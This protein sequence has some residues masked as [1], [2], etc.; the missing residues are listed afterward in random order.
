MRVPAGHIR[1]GAGRCIWAR[2]SRSEEGTCIH[3][4]KSYQHTVLNGVEDIGP[5]WHRHGERQQGG[6]SRDASSRA[7]RQVCLHERQDMPH[8]GCS[9]ATS[10][11][12]IP[13]V[14]HYTGLTGQD[15]S[16]ATG[17]R[18]CYGAAGRV[19]D[20]WRHCWSSC[21]IA[22]CAPALYQRPPMLCDTTPA[23]PATNSS[24]SPSLSSTPAYTS[25]PSGS[26][27]LRPVGPRIPLH[28]LAHLA[29]P[30]LPKAL[31]GT[32]LSAK[33]P[34][35]L[36]TPPTPKPIATMPSLADVEDWIE[37]QW[38]AG[39]VRVL[40]CSEAHT[41]AKLMSVSPCRAARD[42]SASD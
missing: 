41:D 28:R 31:L 26:G 20:G 17:H 34:P 11:R 9:P 6:W 10:E 40:G 18:V 2:Q 36:S 7:Q 30:H 33:P 16:W 23:H 39:L 3:R 13:Y 35:P 4:A 42:A 22:I 38:P 24:C 12:R 29:V 1:G 32:V 14:T 15:R 19:S 25:S 27:S 8:R 37:S 5:G 21:K